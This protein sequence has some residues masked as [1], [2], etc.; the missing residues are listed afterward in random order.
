MQPSE[1]ITSL[2]RWANKPYPISA[3]AYDGEVL[4][5]RLSGAASAVTAASREIGGDAL[6]TGI[7]FWA[8]VRELTHPFFTDDAPLWRLSLP[9][10]TPPLTLS[11]RSFLDWGGAQ[12]WLLSTAPAEQIRSLAAH[13]GGYATLFRGGDRQGEVFH[14]LEPVIERLHRNLKTSFDPQGIFN[15][16]RMYRTF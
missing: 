4:Y 15:P 3:A 16:G 14:P 10:A 13:H 6:D 8:S 7:L 5:L 11:G 12:R 9:P 2:N 1:A